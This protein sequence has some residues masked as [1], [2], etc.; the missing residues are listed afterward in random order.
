M[1]GQRPLE[2]ALK[3]I[4]TDPVQRFARQLADDA[5]RGEHFV[6]AC[7]GQQRTVITLAEVLVVAAQVDYLRTTGEVVAVLKIILGQHQTLAGQV[8]GPVFL[9]F[10]Q[11]QQL[12][13]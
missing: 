2:C 3:I 9:A 7:F 1:V 10:D 8:A 12:A 13:A 6:P 5:Y 11:N 4:Q